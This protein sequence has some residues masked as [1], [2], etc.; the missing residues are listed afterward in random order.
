M[1]DQPTPA[2]RRKPTRMPETQDF[3]D[4]YPRPEYTSKAQ[5][6]EGQE[7]IKKYFELQK[8]SNPN[9]RI[10]RWKKF[11][12]QKESGAFQQEAEV[13]NEDGEDEESEQKDEET[14]YRLRTA[15]VD[16]TYIM[17]TGS[18]IG[19]TKKYGRFDD[20]PSKIKGKT[21]EF[22]IPHMLD[23]EFDNWL[24]LANWDEVEEFSADERREVKFKTVTT[25]LMRC[26]KRK[27]AIVMKQLQSA[28]G[29]TD[30]QVFLGEPLLTDMEIKVLVN[31]DYRL[32]LIFRQ[33]VLIN[34]CIK[35]A[36]FDYSFLLLRLLRFFD[37][38]L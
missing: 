25:T 13:A 4:K 33:D 16:Q 24:C 36:K 27:L 9:E 26:R 14:E 7:Y 1:S 5:E 12:D 17:N 37:L 15:E 18:T 35:T 11:I 3:A 22:A 21:T 6:K 23:N 34:Y 28:L 38:L 20:V 19:M 10:K 30:D 31:E 29:N 32:V 2:K 8:I